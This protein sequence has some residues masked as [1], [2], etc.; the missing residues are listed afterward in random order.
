MVGSITKQLTLT[1]KNKKIELFSIC[2]KRNRVI[3]DKEDLKNKNMWIRGWDSKTDIDDE[4]SLKDQL[5]NGTIS[6]TKATRIVRQIYRKKA[7]KR[8]L[9]KFNGKN[10]LPQ[11]K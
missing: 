1:K 7:E 6:R 8:M 11:L 5:I 2:D 4:L 10:I 3:I 9:D